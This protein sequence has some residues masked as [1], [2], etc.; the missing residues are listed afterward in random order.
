VYLDDLDV[1]P[2]F[3]SN[4]NLD[5]Q[6]ILPR[7]KLS[8]DNRAYF[9]KELVQGGPYTHVRLSI[10]PDGGISRLRLWGRPEARPGVEE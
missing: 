8:A 4:R 2:D 3:L 9:D 6:P 10:F 1:P 5:W 7:T